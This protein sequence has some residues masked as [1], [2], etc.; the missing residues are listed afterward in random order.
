MKCV[1]KIASYNHGSVM[2]AL[3]DTRVNAI[4][5]YI[6]PS[7]QCSSFIPV[8][9]KFSNSS[10]HDL[11]TDADEQGWRLHGFRHAPVGNDDVTKQYE[12]V[13]DTTSRIK[14]SGCMYV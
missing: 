7:L 5:Q 12:H 11:A 9:V 8:Y 13:T 1:Y 14:F 10:Q 3:C 6:A 4:K 2:R